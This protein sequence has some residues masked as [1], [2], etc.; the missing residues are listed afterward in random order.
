MELKR[1]PQSRLIKHGSIII[2]DEKKQ[3][4]KNNE[5]DEIENKS[6]YKT[7]DLWYVTYKLGSLKATNI[8]NN[9]KI[10]RNVIIE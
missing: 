10:T 8:R 6:D 2:K 7:S 9:P 4:S 5:V 3:L 1:I